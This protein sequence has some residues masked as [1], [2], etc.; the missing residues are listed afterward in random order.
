MPSRRKGDLILFSSE[1]PQPLISWLVEA[2]GLQKVLEML[3]R[4]HL[5]GGM[6]LAS[7]A[8]SKNGTSKKGGKRGRPKGSKNSSKKGAKKSSKKV[9]GRRK[10]PK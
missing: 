3:S 6:R 1:D 2:H 10:I 9:V 4:E 7:K 5:P 8:S